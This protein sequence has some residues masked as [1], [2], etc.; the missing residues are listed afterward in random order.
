MIQTGGQEIGILL[1]EKT[2]AYPAEGGS[3]TLE[4][5]RVAFQAELSPDVQISADRTGGKKTLT[6]DSGAQITA[7]E[8]STI[9]ITGRLERG[10]VTVG[11]GMPVDVLEGNAFR[12]YRLSDG[13]ELLRVA[14][15]LHGPA[16]SYTGGVESFDDLSEAAQK[17]VLEYYDGR[18]VLYDERE[19]LEKTYALYQEEGGAFLSGWVEQSVSPIASSG[20]VMYFLTTITLPTGRENGNITYETRLCDAFDRETG[21]H[22]DT[23]DL[24][25]AP[26]DTVM[27]TIL[28]ESGISVQPLRAEMEA[29]SWD[30]R[31]AFF[32][33]GLSVEFEPGALPSQTEA[34]GLFVDHT[35]AVKDL[36][37]DWAA[38]ES[39]D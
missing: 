3:W 17:Q 34:T 38:P 8:A 21:V 10:A 11:D 14:A 36:I 32:P 24:F 28:D 2:L 9:R 6:T 7:Y 16:Y 13:T 37:Q 1:T 35:S 25:R 19:E 15:E 4:E 26:K 39:R 22:I 31:I 18:G 12:T 29:A 23:W 20:R 27:R 5:M 33:D 30:G